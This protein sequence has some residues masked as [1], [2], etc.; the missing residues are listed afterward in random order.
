[1]LWFALYINV[2]IIILTA[3]VTTL[4]NQ[5]KAI[6]VPVFIGSLL[7]MIL[8]VFK[9]K[10]IIIGEIDEYTYYNISIFYTTK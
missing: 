3:Y 5:Y 8:S 4:F 7:I 2:A 1:M 6:I 9:D 10:K